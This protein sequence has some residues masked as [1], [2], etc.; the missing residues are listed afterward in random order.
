MIKSFSQKCV[1]L[2]CLLMSFYGYAVEKPEDIAKIT[3]NDVP[4]FDGSDSTDPLRAILIYKLLDL[5]YYWMRRGQ[6]QNDDDL[7]RVGA[8]NIPYK[9]EKYNLFMSKNEKSNTH[10][11][12]INLIDGTVDLTITAR[13]ISRDETEYAIE[14]DV[15]L[16][17]KPI[18]RDALIFMVNNDSPIESLSLDEI[19][20]IY[21]KEILNWQSVGGP[22][23]EITPYIRN[24]NSG[25][26]EKFETMVMG[27]EYITDFEL[28]YVGTAM[29]A[30]YHQIERDVSGIA[31]TPYYYY[32]TI[33]DTGSTKKIRLEGVIPCKE[34]LESGEYPLCTEVYASIR[35]DC[36]RESYTFKIYESLTS[37]WGR[38]VIAESKYIPLP[39]QT[40]I[41]SLTGDNGVV[42]A[43]D[44]VKL[45]PD[46]EY[47]Y[48]RVYDLTGALVK[49]FSSPKDFLDI[50]DLRGGIYILYGADSQGKKFTMKFSR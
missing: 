17:S 20:R 8:Y 33:V 23:M 14:K 43:P 31:F 42:F 28:F 26:Q 22:D 15:T 7:Y 39:E 44:F 10:G 35:S 11:S 36:D 19:R 4:V 45:P 2:L 21:R 6:T 46:D 49:D 18:A 40:G 48:I 30:P 5:E 25:S 9:G 29:L 12:F 1:L 41:P 13:D 24:R 16:I 32:D 47:I 34:T 37:D 3:L 27:G 50:S 38:D